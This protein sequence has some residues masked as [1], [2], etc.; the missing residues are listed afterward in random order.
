MWLCRN[1]LQKEHLKLHVLW[2]ALIKSEYGWRHST[3]L[4]E[5]RAKIRESGEYVDSKWSKHP[6]FHRWAT[7]SH[8]MLAMRHE[9]QVIRMAMMGI[10][11]NSPLDGLGTLLSNPME[12]FLGSGLVTNAPSPE[13]ATKEFLYLKEKRWEK[14]LN[15]YCG[16]LKIKSTLLDRECYIGIYDEVDLNEFT[17][18]K[19]FSRG[20]SIDDEFRITQEDGVKSIRPEWT[21]GCATNRFKGRSSEPPKDFIPYEDHI[22]KLNNR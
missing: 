3:Q 19:A 2:N 9:A 22:K 1:H 12:T 4:T 8:L 16:R 10:H 17:T 6:E 20:W 18:H 21:I 15:C 13:Q 14:M 7:M 5:H 11:H